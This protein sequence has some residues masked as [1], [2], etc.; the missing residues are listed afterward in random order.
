MSDCEHCGARLPD[1]ATWCGQ[2]L[3]PVKPPA[4]TATHRRVLEPEQHAEPEYSRWRGGPASFGPVVK[5]A[6]T[7]FVL[8]LGPIGG[9]LE[10]RA[11]WLI[12][13]GPIAALVLWGTWRKQRVA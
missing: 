9:M 10:L 1:D 5:I 12:A 4:E 13:W 11:L 3:E 6:I 7:V 2:C 8:A